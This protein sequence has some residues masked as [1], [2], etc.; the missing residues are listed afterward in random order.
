MKP[1]VTSG[2]RKTA[3]ARAT[4][5]KGDGTVRV[6][7]MLLDHWGTNLARLKVMEP[8]ELAGPKATMVDIDIN[9]IGGGIMGQ[10]YAMRTAIARGIVQYYNDDGLEETFRSFDRSLLVNDDRRKEAKKPLGRGAR[11]KRQK[12]YR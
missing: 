5:S 7:N 1:V 8:I 6:N 11:Q 4:V 9:V 3:I 2:K 10:A 12:S